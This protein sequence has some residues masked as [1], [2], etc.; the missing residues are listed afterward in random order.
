[1]PGL[2]TEPSTHGIGQHAY[3]NIAYGDHGPEDTKWIKEVIVRLTAALDAY[4]KQYGC[5]I[6]LIE[7]KGLPPKIDR[8]FNGSLNC[9]ESV[10]GILIK[11]PRNIAAA[12]KT[13]VYTPEQ[14]EQLTVDIESKIAHPSATLQDEEQPGKPGHSARGTGGANSGSNFIFT[15][16]DFDAQYH[17]ATNIYETYNVKAVKYSNRSKLILADLQIYL[18]ILKFCHE[19]PNTDGSLPTARII[20]LW[21]VFNDAGISSRKSDGKRLATLRNLLSDCGWI[22]WQDNGYRRGSNGVAGQAMRWAITS[23][24]YSLLEERE[25]EEPSCEEQSVVLPIRTLGLRPINL[26]YYTCSFDLERLDALIS[27]DYLLSAA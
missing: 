13:C 23:E 17:L 1:M 27:A 9:S 4:V 24:F 2:Y 22:K 10:M 3:Y 19:T 18:A 21:R 14:L 11:A 12:V 25:E 8:A 7:P 15:N 20:T 26:G 16:E 5:D 6:N